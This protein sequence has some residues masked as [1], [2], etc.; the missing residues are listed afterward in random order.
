MKFLPVLRSFLREHKVIY[1]VRG[2]DMRRAG[3]VVEGVGACRRIPLG[4][5][6]GRGDLASYVEL[7]GFS[8]LEEWYNKIDE[9]IVPGQGM[10]LYRVEVINNV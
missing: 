5:I 7:S 9:F 8:S 3:V 4:R 10:W 1:T 6:Y 2:Y